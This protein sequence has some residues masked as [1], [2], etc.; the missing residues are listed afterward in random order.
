M[1]EDAP[2]KMAQTIIGMLNQRKVPVE[3]NTQMFIIN[4]AGKKIP[5]NR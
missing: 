3:W 5:I 1:H 4:A 2:D